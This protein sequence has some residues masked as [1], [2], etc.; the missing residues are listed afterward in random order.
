M[1]IKLSLDALSDYL[2]EKGY[3]AHKKVDQISTEL[4]AGRDKHPFF[5]KV[6]GEGS[7]VQLIVFL[8][9]VLQQKHASDVARLLHYY[10]KEID[11]PGFGIDEVSGGV[12]YR[13]VVI[14]DD[15]EVPRRLMDKVLGAVP[16]LCENF[17]P[18]VSAAMAGA[19]RF[20]TMLEKLKSKNLKK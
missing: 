12:F 13:C 16:K 10:N 11:L 9:Y 14:G 1:S 20:D 3:D 6:D 19:L 7:L 18:L 2:R 4:T 15:G 5:V 17:F 8:P